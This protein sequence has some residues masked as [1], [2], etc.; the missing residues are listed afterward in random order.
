VY[1]KFACFLSIKISRP[2]AI[3][4]IN[5]NFWSFSDAPN[6]LIGSSSDLDTNDCG[7]RGDWGVDDDDWGEWP[8]ESA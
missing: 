4:N 7:V 1:F 3:W 2:F 8:I 5:Q 6:I